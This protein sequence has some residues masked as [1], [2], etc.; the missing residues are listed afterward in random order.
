MLAADIEGMTEK[1]YRQLRRYF[2]SWVLLKQSLHES[3]ELPKIASLPA[4]Q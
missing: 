1:R 2:S 4:E 3:R